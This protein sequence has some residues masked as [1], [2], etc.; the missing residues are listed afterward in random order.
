[1]TAP[2]DPRRARDAARERLARETFDVLVI[3]GGITGAGVALDA[4][5]RGLRTAIVDKGD[6]ASGTSSKSS[7]LIHGGLRYLQQKEYRLVFENLRERQRLLENA[8]HLVRVMPFLIPLFGK[9]GIVSST[10]AKGYQTALRLYDLVG[11]WRVGKLHK[12]I[13]VEETV[14]H[15]GGLA[16]DRVVAG[17]LY[18]DAQ[19]DDAR[20]TLSLIRSAQ[21]HDAVALNH[22]AVTALHR[23]G[24]GNVDGAVLDDGTVVRARCVVNAAG[25]WAEQIGAMGGEI[26]YRIRPAKGIHVTVPADKIRADIA[27]VIPVRADRRS[28]FVVPA[29]D[30]PSSV[31]GEPPDRIYIGTTDTDYVGPLDDPVCT[32]DD[33]RYVIDAMNDWLAEPLTDADVLGTW[34]GLRPLLSDARS[35]RTADLSRRHKVTRSSSGVVSILG[36]KLTTYRQMAEDTVD[37]VCKVLGHKARCRTRSLLLHG[38]DRW[39]GALTVPAGITLSPQVLDD[40]RSRHG[41]DAAAVLALTAEDH[42]LAQP[43]VRG[44]PY[45]RAEV[46]WA[47]RAEHA[48]TVGDVLERRLRALLLA[49]DAAADAAPECARLLGREL[50]WDEAE[51]QRQVASFLTLVD[52]ERTAER[53]AA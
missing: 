28:V 12:R 43:I 52:A 53:G 45:L 33:V 16:G 23:D 25:V 36:G 11:G 17:F 24:S 46:V 14:K 5:T 21:E 30:S 49:R 32:P 2:A 20:L 44:L 26:D 10:V 41:S 34:A 8:P 19:A 13:T 1:M 42:S 50:G 39:D 47:A 27:A 18:Y 7:K 38:A 31:A 6:W 4:A 22:A 29:F 3:G 51:Q 48:Y 35:E 9:G 37:E 40:L 15:M